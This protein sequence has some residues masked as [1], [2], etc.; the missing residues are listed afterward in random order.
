MRRKLNKKGIVVLSFIS[1]ILLLIIISFS[2]YFLKLRAVSKDSVPVSFRVE[3][4]DTYSSISKKLINSNLLRSDLAYKIYVKTHKLNT[5]KVGIYELNQN[6]S[7]GKILSVL[8]SDNYKEDYVEITF[9]EGINM[10]HI[11]SLISE[12]T[13]NSE[14]DVYN[15]LK[16]RDYLNSLI[17]KYWFI[18]DEILD[19][20]IY[21]PLEGYLFP[22]T[23]QFS[24]NASVQDIF[25]AMLDQ[26]DLKLSNYKEQINNSGYSVHKLLTLAS[27]VELEAGMSHEMNGIASVFYNRINS[28]WTLGS[29]VTTYY[30]SRKDFTVDLTINELNE[31][32]GY[33]TRG[34]CFT[35]LPVGPISS[36]SLESIE[37]VINPVQSD[38]YYFVADKYGNTYFSKTDSEHMAIISK[39][40][41]EGLWYVY[42]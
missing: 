12:H 16:N 27:I 7:V 14:D 26:M 25:K 36:P 33:N 4:G 31:C 39:L 17:E 24:M 6:M 19:Q 28:G 29:D 23:Y 1:F 15:L 30:A 18:T 22:D 41:S 8:S 20:R 21:Y 3:E 5:L 40:K 35:G 13:S 32:N 38:Y 9:K 42:E 37:G 34:T 11:A 10:R 2:T